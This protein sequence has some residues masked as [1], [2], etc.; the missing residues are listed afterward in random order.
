VP[1]NFGWIIDGELAG[2]ARPGCGLELSGEM[3]PHER[4]FLSW[5]WL[6]PDR[7]SDRLG[8]AKRIGLRTSDAFQA[9]RRMLE[10]Y[11]KFRDIWGILASYRE[12]FG[13]EGNAV[14]R[15][16]MATER[17]ESDL[18][19]LTEQGVDSIA[20]MTETPL[21]PDVIGASGL[22]V[23]HLPVVDRTAPSQEQI[24]SFVRF[25]D[26][27]LEGGHRV[28][29]HCLGG[30]GRTGTMLACYLVRRGMAAA[31]AIALV[32]ER[33]PGSIEEE[34]QEQA[35]VDYEERLR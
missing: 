6:H 14:D 8:L 9:E 24:D 22:E 4:R 2:M 5:L 32:R 31:E 11:R 21:D 29:A 10:M 3:M 16:E 25:V 19:F 28:V 18:A 7:S 17:L 27:R 30:Y 13:S 20:S 15:F 26:A 33:R 12:G 34:V 35:V 23:I 1:R